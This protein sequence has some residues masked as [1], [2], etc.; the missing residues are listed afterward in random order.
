MCDTPNTTPNVAAR[1]SIM[2]A[3][4]LARRRARRAAAESV[5]ALAELQ[6]LNNCYLSAYV[7]VIAL[8]LVCACSLAVYRAQ[9]PCRL[10]AILNRR[11]TSLDRHNARLFRAAPRS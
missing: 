8:I 7:S 2:H 3:A 5:E 10:R 11:A 6:H 9:S 1:M 4:A